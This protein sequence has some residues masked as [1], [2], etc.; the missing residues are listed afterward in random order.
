MGF[1]QDLFGT[2]GDASKAAAAKVQGLQNAQNYAE[3]LYQQGRTDINTGYGQAANLFAPAV[4]T[5]QGG[6]SAYADI[7]GAAG[8]AGQDR[9]RALFQ[10]DPGYQF[11]RDEAL[12]ATQ[13]LNTGGF[14]GSGNV[15]AALEDRASGL[16]QQQYGNYVNRLAP[17]L[18][19]DLGATTGAAGVA[20]GQ[21]NALNASDISQANL[22]AGI[23]AGEGA[24]TAGGIL[25]DAQS[26]AAGIN[27]IFKIAGLAAAPF[28]GG[29]SLGLLGAGGSGGGG[30][31][32]TLLGYAPGSAGANNLSAGIGNLFGYTGQ[33]YGPGY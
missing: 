18:G 6:A 2:G 4:A 15:A 26:R 9:A 13:R 31:G 5:G 11:A 29:A 3:P 24:A 28:T 12:Q 20:T 7:T 22:G 1:F 30:L 21:A 25:G 8:Q 33:A 16:A 27:N 32:S 17:F 19:Y 23:Q 10:T 14:Q